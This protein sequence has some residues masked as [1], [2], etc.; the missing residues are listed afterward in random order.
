MR[1]WDGR[2]WSY[3]TR[4]APASAAGFGPAGSSALTAARRPWWEHWLV[5]AAGLL[6]CFPVGLVGLWLRRGTSTKV[7]SLVTASTVVLVVVGFLAPGNSGSPPS[8]V[9]AGAASTI[10]STSPSSSPGAA[11]SSSSRPSAAPP[12]SLSSLLSRVPAVEGLRLTQAKRALRAA[13]LKAGTVDRRPSTRAGT[14]LQQR[15]R[16]GKRVNPGSSVALVVAAPL[17]RVP[18][19]IGKSKASATRALKHAGFTVRTTTRTR[20]SGRSGVVL[21][22]SPRG[23]TRAKPNSTVRIVIAKVRRKAPPSPNCTPG[24]SP[25]L[26]PASDYDCAGGTGNGPKYVD[27]PV[28]VAGSDPYELDADG[29]GVGC[30]SS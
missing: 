27:G 22:Q 19:V 6:L 13:G 28:D 17:P 15:V 9:S 29:D 30:Q 18:S 20:T 25:C 5:I 4:P 12:A 16:A 14:V 24:Y 26:P 11:R 21:N 7:K 23:T 1:Y 2:G 3:H 10:Q 8:T